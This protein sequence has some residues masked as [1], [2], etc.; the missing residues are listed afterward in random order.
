M[1]E[2]KELSD[3]GVNAQAGLEANES[4]RQ[5]V[6][7]ENFGAGYDTKEEQDLVKEALYGKEIED[8]NNSNAAFEINLTK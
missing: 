4:L 3:T 5:N 1:R 2:N 8:K 6:T 7:S